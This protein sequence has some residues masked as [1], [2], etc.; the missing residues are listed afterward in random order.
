VRGFPIELSN[1]ALYCFQTAATS[2]TCADRPST[3]PGCAPSC[4]C[5]PIDIFWLD[6]G[7]LE[8]KFDYLWPLSIV[9]LCN[10][11]QYGHFE[12]N[13]EPSHGMSASILPLLAV[14]RS[15]SQS[16]LGYGWRARMSGIQALGTSPIKIGL[17]TQG[18]MVRKRIAGPRTQARS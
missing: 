15:Y 11:R 10:P 8:S 2:C 13:I 17:P 4:S 7:V 12:A 14:A 16:R 1:A 5:C 9:A 6:C 3:A 18:C